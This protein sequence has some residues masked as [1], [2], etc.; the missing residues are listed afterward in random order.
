MLLA[1]VVGVGEGESTTCHI[2][3]SSSSLSTRFLFTDSGAG[4]DN[5]VGAANEKLGM[6]RKLK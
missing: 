1:G 6:L 3:S 5:R 4:F 2:S